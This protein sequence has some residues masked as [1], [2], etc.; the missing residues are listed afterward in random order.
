V[1]VTFL[2]PPALVGKL[3]ADRVYGCNFGYY[4]VPNVFLL[5]A[6]A[7]LEREGYDVA[8]VDGALDGWSRRELKEFLRTDPSDLYL[9]FTVYLSQETDQ[10]TLEMLRES[11]GDVPFVFLGTVP[12]EV[13]ARFLSD[14]HTFVARGEPE[15]TLVEFLAAMREGRSFEDI[16]GLS[17]L[18]GGEKRHNAMRPV[19]KDIDAMPFPARRLIEKWKMKY[20]NPKIGIRPFTVVLASRGC[21]YR[22]KYCVPCSSSFAMEHEYKNYLGRKPPVRQRSPENILAEIHMLRDEG[23]RAISFMD[24]QF[25]WGEQRALDIAEG[26]KGLDMEWGCLARADRL[27]EPVVRAFAASGCRY[28]DVGVES[29]NQAILDDIKKD[30]KVETV[31]R[32]VD[33]LKKHRITC[34]VNM[35]IGASPLETEETIRESIAIIRKIRPDSVMYGIANPFPG[36]E[37][38]DEAKREGWMLY[39]EYKPVDVQKECIISYPHLPRERIEKLARQANLRFFLSPRFLAQNIR[40]IRTLPDFLKACV[41]YKRKLFD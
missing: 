23:Y 9:V 16:L 25:V 38:H 17:Y 3:A 27:T 35:L 14:E 22:C 2:T 29:F 4:P 10:L 8:Y 15:Q 41:A 21:S 26:L 11:R 34:K 30:M 7:V 12:S 32:A 28:I 20:Y 31:Y 6:A 39:D 5:T 1:K 36:T 18:A 37:F 24:D 19:M 33:L 13:P 40:K